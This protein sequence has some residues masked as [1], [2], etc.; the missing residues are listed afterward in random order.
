M[1]PIPVHVVDPT[2]GQ[3]VRT[4]APIPTPG[5]T[6]VRTAAPN[7]NPLQRFGDFVNNNVIQPHL[8]Q[9][10]GGLIDQVV[11]GPGSPGRSVADI[12]RIAAGLVTR[13][14]AA[15]SKAAHDFVTNNVQR[16]QQAAHNIDVLHNPAAAMNIAGG[17]EGGMS[18]ESAAAGAA[19]DAAMQSVGDAA[20]A[21]VEQLRSARSTPPVSKAATR[22]AETARP[23][24]PTTTPPAEPPRGSSL[25]QNSTSGSKPSRFANV[26]VQNSD[27]VDPLTKQLVQEKNVQYQPA[28]TKAGQAAAKQT[29]GSMDLPRAALEVTQKLNGE[30]LG[31]I[32]RQDVFNAHEVA[33]RLQQSANPADKAAAADIY[34]KLS[35]HHT[36]AGQQIQ[37]AAALAKQSPEGMLYS[38]TKALQQHGVKLEGKTLDTVNKAI[39]EYK[40]QTKGINPDKMTRQQADAQSLAYQKFVDI[41][42]KQIPRGKFNAGIGIWRAGLLTGPETAVKVATS[43]FVNAPVELASKPVSDF[44]DRLTSLVTGQRGY[45][46]NRSDLLAGAKGYARGVKAAG[47]KIKTGGD[48]PGTGGFEPKLGS[49][50]RMTTY[51]KI[52]TRLHG[53]IPKPT[54]AAEHEMS[55]RSQARAAAINQ[56]LKGAQRDAFIK[57]FVTNPSKQAL[58]TANHEAEVFT[59][60]NQTLL[61]K[62]AH[63]VQSAPYV[64]KILAPFTRIPGAIGTKGLVDWTPLGLGK[65]AVKVIQGIRNGN[66]DQRGFSQ[67]VGRSLTGTTAGAAVG[68]ELMQ[69]GRMTLAA[70]NDPKE[71][72]LWIQQGRQPNSIY[73]GGRVTRNADGT[74]TYQGGKWISLNAMGPLG[75]T[76]GLGGGY[77]NARAQNKDVAT[78]V[79]QAAAAGGKVLASQPYLKGISGAANAVNDPTRYAQTFLDSTV[80]SVIPAF[81]SQIAR[82]T[83]PTQRAYNPSVAGTIKGE[84]PGLRETLPAQRDIF[85]QP[86]SSGN[87]GNIPGVSGAVQTVNPFYPLSPRSQNDPAA[88]ELQRLYT[89]GGSQNAPA[90]AAP[91]KSMTINGK[92]TAL[93]PEQMDKY[94][95]TSGPLIQSGINNL[96]QSPDYQALPDNK[97]TAQINDVINAARTAAKVQLFGDNPKTLT[98]VERTAILNP[99][100]LGKN[101]SLTGLHLAD[102]IDPGSKGILTKVAGMDTTTK[103]QWMNDP[104]NKF[105]YDLAS[106]R[107]DVLNGKLDPVQQFQKQQTL[108]KQQITSNYSNEVSQL[109]GMSKA[110]ITAYLNSHQDQASSLESQLQSL[111]QALYA[112]GFSSSL[113]FKNGISGSGSGGTGGGS[114]KIQKTTQPFGNTYTRLDSLL[115][116]TEKTVRAKAVSGGGHVQLRQ[117]S[118]KSSKPS[119]YI[120]RIAA[121]RGGSHRL[122]A[123]PRAP[124]YPRVKG[125]SVSSK[126]VKLSV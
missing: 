72:A 116:G 12:G 28:P 24:A 38:A 125:A 69:A 27:K 97:K 126:R 37:A 23:T 98:G 41:V 82:G 74:T 88:H 14:P 121:G 65:A 9:P 102:N 48:L 21:R 8:V 40:Q 85:G 5:R 80:G 3:P 45:T 75:I 81:S 11:T 31:K 115:K 60:Q 58:E 34:A 50:S 68:Y 35:E 25:A 66:F 4:P 122:A 89:A 110:E 33:S 105:S 73:I 106:F 1:G 6:A 112:A 92:K 119:N 99:A 18:P 53:A 77:Q 61:G 29:Y 19:K 64:G 7:E 111:D 30:P 39:D 22:T 108:G 95:A 118:P 54:F 109:Y 107:N 15:T 20:R 26:T 79:V 57:D 47:I 67:D 63:G 36:A 44:V 49:S 59:N 46:F 13:N 120:G 10:I 114:S 96:L 117:F 93:T 90:F 43:H 83:D 17:V 78:S 101:I 86:V 91:Q 62:A 32:T 16:L 87:N 71:K 70:P 42:N 52:P 124:H 104:K 94:V 55:L 56:G 123:S 2:N 76:L 84:I 113:K 103:T 100:G 51:E